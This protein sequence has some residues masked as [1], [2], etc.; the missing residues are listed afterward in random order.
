MILNKK[1]KESVL[2][3]EKLV[4]NFKLDIKVHGNSVEKLHVPAFISKSYYQIQNLNKPNKLDFSYNYPPK[5][6]IE[7]DFTCLYCEREGPNYHKE[8]CNRPFNSSLVLYRETNKYPGA[9]IGT[10]YELIVKKSGQKKIVSKRARSETFTDNVEIFYENENEQQTV[11]RVSRNGT[12][13]IISASLNDTSL[14]NLL[15]YRI[16]QTPGAVLNPPFV[17]DQNTSYRYLVSGQFNL[18]NKEHVVNLNLVHTNLWT[19]PLFKK[20]IQGK[21]AFMIESGTSYFVT[22][23]NYNSGDQYSRSNKTTNPYIQFVLLDENVKVNVMIYVR[24]AVQLRASHLSENH[25]ADL[26]ITVLKKFYT[27]VSKLLRDVIVYSKEA[28]YDIIEPEIKPTKKSKVPN[29]VDGGQPKM[30]H[31]RSG[32]VPGSGDFR[33]VP[34][35]FSGVCPMENY[36]VAPRGVRRPDGKIEPCCKKLK[37]DPTSPDYIGRFQNMLLN[38]YHDGLFDETVTP[39]DAA[40]FIPG[41][42][43]QESRAFAGLKNTPKEHLVDC[44][45]DYIRADTYIDFKKS[46]HVPKFTFHPYKPLVTFDILTKNL[47]MVAPV[48]SGTIRVKLYISETGKSYFVNEMGDIAES[49]IKDSIELAGTELEGYLYPFDNFVFYPIDVN[50]YKNKKVNYLNQSRWNTLQPILSELVPESIEIKTHFDLNIVQGS[51]YFINTFDVDGLLFIPYKG[52]ET[53]IWND[54]HNELYVSLDVEK[55]N[56]NRWKVF[57]E[58]RTLPQELVQQGPNNDIEIPVSFTR[59]KEEKLI[60]LFKINLKKTDFKIENRKPFIPVEILSEH[61]NTYPEVVSLLESIRSPISKDTFINLATPP[62]FV[63]NEKV[64]SFVKIGEPLKKN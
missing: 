3:L 43:V 20:K 40:T 64:Y 37:S 39:G 25:T 23:Y 36:Y 28:N 29:M 41:T 12:I 30:C 6:P 21:D 19:I 44:M 48:L 32:T 62:G 2:N 56:K 60:V 31:N 54:T 38:G 59:N 11:I 22:G 10:R 18:N 42:K 52:T 16:N 1:G 26:D 53:F 47:Y 27:F 61:I 8:S 5:G 57:L 35:S 45:K 50:T 55:I 9:E 33:P 17:L 4:T 49:G 34:Y 13:N 58:N 24:G 7:K 63:F 46:I 14:P 51:Q 15:V